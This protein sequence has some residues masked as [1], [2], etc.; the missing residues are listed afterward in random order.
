ML[1]KINLCHLF[2]LR[3]ILSSTTKT[4]TST[5]FHAFVDFVGVEFNSLLVFFFMFLY[6]EC[7]RII[8]NVCISGIDCQ[9]F[10]G[11]NKQPYCE[12]GIST[13]FFFGVIV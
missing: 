4:T 9:K 7:D 6:I 3:S 8:L 11:F 12:L 13:L 2:G 10:F 1:L 5:P